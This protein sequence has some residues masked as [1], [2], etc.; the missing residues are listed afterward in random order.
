MK[1]YKEKITKIKY[2]GKRKPSYWISKA[3]WDFFNTWEAKRKE[4]LKLLNKTKAD[5]YS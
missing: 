5:L 3:E 2:S 1:P 4:L